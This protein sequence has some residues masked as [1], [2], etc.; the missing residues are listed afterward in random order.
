MK[1]V[2]V[3][4]PLNV[5]IVELPMPEIT[6][7]DEVL[8]K[9][10]SGGICGSDI[11]IFSGGNALA[12]YPRV[13]G[14]EFAGHVAAVGSGVKDL[15]EG[16]LVVA[17]IVNSCG[18][19]YACRSGHHNVCATLQ[20]TGV[21]RDGGFAEYC[22]T[23]RDKI[24]KLDAAKIPAHLACL[25]EPYSVGA[26][27]N[28]R[29]NITA[30]DKVVVL[31][32]GPAGL[33]IMEVARARGADVLITDIF[34]RRLELARQMGATRSVNVQH[35]DLRAAVKDFT[36]G[37]GAH[38][39][40]DAVCSTQS[41]LDALDIV[42]PAGRF[43]ALGTGAE[44]VPIPQIAFTKKGINVFGTRVNNHRFPEVIRLFEEGRVHPAI[45]HTHTFKFT[46][47][48]DAFALLRSDKSQ[49]CKIILEW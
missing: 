3:K 19:C 7:P 1:A 45:M 32:A 6:G 11:G 41:V 16:D 13:I 18:Q 28:A 31:G 49:V 40:A 27:V 29:A 46:A 21:H 10:V 15:A 8:I 30:D 33:A 4:E 48:A 38:V 36:Q 44:P 2:L 25:V 42:A 24:Y 39:V 23:T 37:D 34:D 17:D 20:V 5:A 12:T 26:E 43:V 35:E 14:H 47:I 9:V 22:K